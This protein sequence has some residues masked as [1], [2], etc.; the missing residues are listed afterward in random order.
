MRYLK[1]VLGL[2][3]AG[4]FSTGCQ[5]ETTSLIHPSD[6]QNLQTSATK[7]R[8]K[9]NGKNTTNPNNKPSAKQIPDSRKNR[10]TGD[11]GYRDYVSFD[12]RGN[13]NWAKPNL[14]NQVD[15]G[16]IF[17]MGHGNILYENMVQLVS[18]FYVPIPG[19]RWGDGE[20]DINEKEP[21]ESESDQSQDGGGN[22][23]NGFDKGGPMGGTIYIQDVDVN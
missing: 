23:Y 11:K 2:A 20:A 16:V 6:V 3:V 10:T 8:S 13:L 15:S 21:K 12:Y 9:G 5:K 4:L 19:V 14:S 18:G 1:L 22:G 17:N 7:G